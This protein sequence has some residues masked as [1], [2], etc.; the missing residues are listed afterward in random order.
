MSTVCFFVLVIEKEG[1]GQ[2]RGY[3][4]NVIGVAATGST[5]EEVEQSL[6]AQINGHVQALT[7][8]HYGREVQLEVTTKPIEEKIGCVHVHEHGH[9]CQATAQK[10]G[11]CWQHWKRLYGHEVD[12]RRRFRKC[13]LCGEDRPY[14]LG[15]W[16]EACPSKATLDNWPDVLAERRLA[17]ANERKSHRDQFDSERRERFYATLP[18][19]CRGIT[20][21]GSQCSNEAQQDGLCKHHWRKAYGHDYWASGP[22]RCN[23]C[24]ES[25][26]DVLVKWDVPCPTKTQSSKTSA[27]QH[28]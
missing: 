19:Q 5:R 12:T 11:L 26:F 9:Q 18:I 27:G 23:E 4:P 24:G 1:E 16:S 15:N 2:Y 13:I 28:G 8:G 7:A 17:S 6:T 25:D 20:A 14:V 3:S 21:R 10:D 22:Q